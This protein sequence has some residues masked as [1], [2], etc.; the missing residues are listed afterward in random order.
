MRGMQLHVDGSNL[1][2][3]ARRPQRMHVPVALAPPSTREV[4]PSQTHVHIP[5]ACVKDFR[6]GLR[7]C[8]TLAV[9]SG[10]LFRLPW[11]RKQ[12]RTP[13]ERALRHAIRHRHDSTARGRRSPHLRWRRAARSEQTQRRRDTCYQPLASV[14][15]ATARQGAGFVGRHTASQHLAKNLPRS[16]PPSKNS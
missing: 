6:F 9:G 15:A 1:P 13:W 3:W 16:A 7:H 12:T 8:Q 10:Q 14:E 4:A 5:R 11:I 2:F